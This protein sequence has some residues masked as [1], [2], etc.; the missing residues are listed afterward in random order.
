MTTDF[1]LDVSISL[2]PALAERMRA[3]LFTEL[4]QIEADDPEVLALE[5][6]LPALWARALDRQRNPFAEVY[7]VSGEDLLDDYRWFAEVIHT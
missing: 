2:E 7:E 3:H 6:D 1:H 5:H 4:R